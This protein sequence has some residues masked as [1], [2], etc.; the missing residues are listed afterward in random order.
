MLRYL[1]PA[2]CVLTLAMPA[3]QAQ[4]PPPAAWTDRTRVLPDELRRLPVGLILWHTPNPNYPE[5]NPDVPGGYVWKHSTAIRAEVGDLQVVSCGS[6]IWYSA[7]GWQA[8]LRQTPAEF[9]KLFNCPG[10]KLKQ[11]VTY[12]FARNYRYAASAKSLYGGDALWFIIAKDAQGR[13]YKGYGL[14]ETEADPQTQE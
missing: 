9:A 3:A 6:Y 5:P 7:A 1:L 13:L 2:L 10:G 14:I 11:G 8:N 12:T 4:T